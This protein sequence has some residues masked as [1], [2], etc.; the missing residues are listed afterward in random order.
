M[1]P[2]TGTA[3][4]NGINNFTGTTNV[5]FVISKASQAIGLSYTSY[6]RE[7]ETTRITVTGAKTPLKW[8]SSDKSVA[9]VNSD[10]VVTGVKTGSARITVTAVE[11]AYYK[12]VQRDINMTVRP[13]DQVRAF[14][15]RLYRVV[16]ERE[17][18]EAG[19]TYWTQ[20]LKN[21]KVTGAE[22][23]SMFFLGDEIKNKHLS[24]QKYVQLAYQGAL[25]R[26]PDSA[27]TAYW[28]DALDSGTSP[29]FLVCG[30][31]ASQEF[32]DMCAGY[33][34][35]KGS[36]S[37]SEERDKNLGV[38]KF[39]SRLY[40]KALGRSYDADGLNYWCGIIN[41]NP[42][43]DNVIQVA[44]DGCFHSQEFLN[45][46]LSNRD[47]VTV[48]YRTFL[49]READLEGYNYWLGQLAGGMS[50][51]EMIRNCAYSQEFSNIMASYGL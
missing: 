2:G 30:C 43:R 13:G 27:G 16:L 36:I 14:V 24:N 41:A 33:G 6:V 29:Q 4:V 39:V 37:V 3:I 23:I 34:I 22:M 11:N 1:N 28:V 35:T 20:Q 46:N 51:D 31:V 47:F 21:G 40:T 42:S 8:E 15:A 45:K 10:G 5:P 19:L 17:P 49:G 12:A 18:E 38:T 44:M 48:A 50:R 9:T 25:G 32:A 7:G 26:N